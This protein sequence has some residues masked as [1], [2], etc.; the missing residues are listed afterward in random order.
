MNARL[1]TAW[2]LMPSGGASRPQNGRTVSNGH[3]RYA[4]PWEDIQL[5]N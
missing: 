2:S 1:E 4:Y 3:D 5:R